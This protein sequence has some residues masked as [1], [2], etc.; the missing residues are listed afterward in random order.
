MYVNVILQESVL[1]R[2]VQETVLRAVDET[3]GTFVEKLS[4]RSSELT[5]LRLL[6]DDRDDDGVIPRSTP[7]LSNPGS[8]SW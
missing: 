8:W 5:C 7:V 2:A 6:S 3:T 1:H 4:R